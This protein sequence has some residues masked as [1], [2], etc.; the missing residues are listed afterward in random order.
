MPFTESTQLILSPEFESHNID[1][2]DG[3]DIKTCF[4]V[5]SISKI[6]DQNVHGYILNEFMA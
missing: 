5:D 2:I 1:E 4:W 3:A 6:V